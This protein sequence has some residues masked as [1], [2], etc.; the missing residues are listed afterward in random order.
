MSK[1]GLVVI[2]GVIVLF[3]SVGNAQKNST[4]IVGNTSASAVPVKRADNPAFQPFRIGVE[5][6]ETK[7][8]PLGKTFVVEHISGYYQIGSPFGAAGPC[9]IM[10]LAI[11][12]GGE[13]IDVIP[14][15]MGTANGGTQDVHLFAFSQPY[16]GYI[17]QG[18]DVPGSATS[19]LSQY[20]NSFPVMYSRVV[21]S[22]YLVDVNQ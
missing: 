6:G 17:S 21:F 8:V 20:C 7:S 12:V 3:A 2:I 15:Y 1:I 22:G 19:N 14:T 10:R 4:V 9:R 16:K 18:S 11:P 13:A 5:W